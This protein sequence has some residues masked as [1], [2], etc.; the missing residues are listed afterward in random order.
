M[1]TTKWFD[2]GIVHAYFN[3]YESPYDAFINYMNV[4]KDYKERLVLRAEEQREGRAPESRDGHGPEGKNQET[5][6]RRRE[7]AERFKARDLGV[8][9]SGE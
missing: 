6:D 2:D 8:V 3:P 1:C 9:A 7:T 5:A 4:M